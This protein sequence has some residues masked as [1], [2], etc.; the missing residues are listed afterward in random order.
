MLS[1]TCPW[2]QPSKTCGKGPCSARIEAPPQAGT[3]GASGKADSPGPSSLPS[4]TALPRDSCVVSCAGPGSALCPSAGCRSAAAS[5]RTSSASQT[6]SRCIRT[7]M[8]AK[9][10]QAK[11]HSES[12]YEARWI[13]VRERKVGLKVSRLMGWTVFGNSSHVWH[14]WPAYRRMYAIHRVGPSRQPFSRLNSRPMGHVA[15]V[16]AADTQFA[17]N[18]QGVHP[19]ASMYSSS[20]SRNCVQQAYSAAAGPQRAKALRTRRDWSS[21]E[22][23][24]LETAIRGATGSEAG[25]GA[26]P[27]RQWHWSHR[28]TDTI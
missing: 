10:R 20:S 11:E 24:P 17:G 4:C 6:F 25:T 18:F 8:S 19:A 28:M 16:A 13:D 14:Y 26:G 3:F 23:S 27:S 12:L 1:G 9:L 15:S 5:S 21:P 22:S 2:A 7:W